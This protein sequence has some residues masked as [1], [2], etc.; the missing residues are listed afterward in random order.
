M[1]PC[2]HHDPPLEGWFLQLCLMLLCTRPG[3]YGMGDDIILSRPSFYS[4]V[5]FGE[6]ILGI[7]SR[8]SRWLHLSMSLR[9]VLY[10][11][12]ES[13]L[14]PMWL[15]LEKYIDLIY[16]AVYKL[17]RYYTFSILVLSWVGCKKCMLLARLDNTEIRKSAKD[18]TLPLG[19]KPYLI[20]EGRVSISLLI[21]TVSVHRHFSVLPGQFMSL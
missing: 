3:T 5:P 2:T 21:C 13:R 1:N 9:R 11:V 19:G 17:Q 14:K 16:L 18:V 6:G 7:E 4:S 20:S 8:A 12:L 10:A 15:Y